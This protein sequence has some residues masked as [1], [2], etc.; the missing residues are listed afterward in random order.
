MSSNQP[1][2]ITHLC[3]EM[4]RLVDSEADGNFY[5][6]REHTSTLTQKAV[7]ISSQIAAIATATIRQDYDPFSEQYAQEQEKLHNLITGKSSRETRETTPGE[8]LSD[9]LW[10]ANPY[11]WDDHGFIAKYQYLTACTTRVVSGA[12]KKRPLK[13]L[14]MGCGRGLTTEILAQ[15]GAHVTG[16]DI[17]PKWTSFSEGRARIRGFQINRIVGEFDNLSDCSPGLDQYDLILF[18]ASLHHCAKP[19]HLI[20]ALTEHLE[21][22]G[23]IAFFEEPVN[24]I[25]WRHWG[26]RLDPESIYVMA[27]FGW[28]ESGWS[29]DFVQAIARRSKIAFKC[30][31][32]QNHDQIGI[33]TH[34]N[35]HL[36]TLTQHTIRFGFEPLCAPTTEKHKPLSN[37]AAQLHSEEEP[38]SALSGSDLHCVVTLKNQSDEP[39]IRYSEFPVN[40]SYHWLR[41]NG[42]YAVY[43]G[44][45][46][47]LPRSEIK[48]GQTVSCVANIKTP[49]EPGKYQLIITLVQEQVAWFE[50]KGLKPLCY[51]IDIN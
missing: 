8:D 48:P 36:N 51:I 11:A 44:E 1:L 35:Q 30:F 16:F 18:C 50:D 37:F 43:D 21:P 42:E 39:W 7:E 46:T 22:D 5:K 24:H 41:P 33:F 17:D 2:E 49:D 34:S 27:K 19:W 38:S 28:L 32:N 23:V 31:N 13:I 12:I 25:W 14:D 29:I 15:T 40:V 45:R 26:L 4:V 3:A 20:E 6:L 10:H 47:P 9:A